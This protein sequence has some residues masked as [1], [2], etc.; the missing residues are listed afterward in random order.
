MFRILL[1]GGPAPLLLQLGRLQQLCQKP[2]CGNSQSSLA[3]P[4]V[5]VAMSKVSCT[6]AGAALQQLGNSLAVAKVSVPRSR[7]LEICVEIYYVFVRHVPSQPARGSRAGRH[8]R[9]CRATPRVLRSTLGHPSCFRHCRRS[10]AWETCS[11]IHRWIR[12]SSPGIA[13][14]RWRTSGQLPEP[15]LR[16]IVHCLYRTLTESR[17]CISLPFHMF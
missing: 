5:A 8:G 16:S 9:W 6:R 14:N 10:Y 13:E 3:M 11:S 17:A 7:C 4:N 15:W 2:R 12:S 1:S